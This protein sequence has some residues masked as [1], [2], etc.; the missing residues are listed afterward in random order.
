MD[1]LMSNAT[2]PETYLGIYSELSKYNI[3]LNIFERLWAVC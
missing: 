2:A 1:T 3:H